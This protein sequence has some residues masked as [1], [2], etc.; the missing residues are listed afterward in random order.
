MRPQLVCSAHTRNG[1]QLLLA[2]PMPW[3]VQLLT[4]ARPAWAGLVGLG[5]CLLP[6]WARR[7]YRL[8][9]LP[10]TDLAAT[11]AVRALRTVALR[12]PES[13]R[14]APPILAARARAELAA[15]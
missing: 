12:L 4:P 14:L 7:L 13:L 6:R 9:G 5:F 11:V 15:A 3:R 8:P 10:T 1:A 2:P